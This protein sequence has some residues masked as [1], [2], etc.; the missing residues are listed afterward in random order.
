M[1][2]INRGNGNR[3][4]DDRQQLN[5]NQKAG[6][7]GVP[8]QFVREKRLQLLSGFSFCVVFHGESPKVTIHRIN[9][10]L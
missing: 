6:D 1:G 9:K 5:D 10:K 7:D 4:K 8:K 3:Q 2:R